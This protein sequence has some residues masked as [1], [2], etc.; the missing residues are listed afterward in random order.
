MSYLSLASKPA[1]KGAEGAVKFLSKP[2][3]GAVE[4]EEGTVT[5]DGGEIQVAKEQEPAEDVIHLSKFYTDDVRLMVPGRDTIIGV[6]GTY[7]QSKLGEL[8]Q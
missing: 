2:D 5:E 4:G 7:V 6:D 1:T 3:E 8:W